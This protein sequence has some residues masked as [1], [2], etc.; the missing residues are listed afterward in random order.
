MDTN[1]TFDDNI[2]DET[3]NLEFKV[4]RIDNSTF[5]RLACK[6]IQDKTLNEKKINITF[7]EELI[8]TKQFNACLV[9]PTLQLNQLNR[10]D[11]VVLRGN[12]NHQVIFEFPR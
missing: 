1:I 11:F 4:G 12:L 10:L 9:F 2:G 3:E 8:K 6:N 5:Y 7:A